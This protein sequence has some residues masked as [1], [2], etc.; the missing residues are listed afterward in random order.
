VVT[1]EA[2]A[3]SVRAGVA[4]AGL[5]WAGPVWAGAGPAWT[6][7]D[8][9]GVVWAL[10]TAATRKGLRVR[11][12]SRPRVGAGVWA[13]P[14]AAARR[15]TDQMGKVFLMPGVQRKV[16]HGRTGKTRAGNSAP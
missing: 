16:C 2:F 14:T 5:A 8:W 1:A 4:P 7:G 9:D 3:A 6:G 12:E 13:L 10:P 15:R 11:V